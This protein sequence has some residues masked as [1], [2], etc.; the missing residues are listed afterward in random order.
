MAGRYLFRPAEVA[1]CNGPSRTR[2][3]DPEI[4]VREGVASSSAVKGRALIAS[5]E[6]NG[7]K[8]RL[9]LA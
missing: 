1:S 6:V 2:V 7:G 8:G 3:K 9:R 5:Q 4:R